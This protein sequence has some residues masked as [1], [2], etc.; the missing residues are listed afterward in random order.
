MSAALKVA[1]HYGVAIEFADLGDWG[2]DD[3]RSEYDPQGPTIRINARI[4][5]T[6][7]ADK[8]DKFVNLCVGHELYHHLEAIGQIDRIVDKRERERAADAFALELLS[9]A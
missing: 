4:A 6:M 9:Q 1:R 8:L 3:L 2:M 5:Q 7:P